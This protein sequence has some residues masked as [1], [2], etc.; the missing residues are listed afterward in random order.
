M[1]W[2]GEWRYKL[3]NYCNNGRY[4]TDYNWMLCGCKTI[5]ILRQSWE[6]DREK[7][8][9]VSESFQIRISPYI[10]FH[11]TY[12]VVADIS[13]IAELVFHQQRYFIGQVQADTT[14][15]RS[16][17][18]K[19]DEIFDRKGH[20]HTALEFDDSR[21][22]FLNTQLTGRDRKSFKLF[23]TDGVLFCWK[24]YAIDGSTSL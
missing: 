21:I 16:C 2:V 1:S 22:V 7:K 6:P 15:Q 20:G 4:N 12:Q 24:T 8:S 13:Q 23:D 3:D 14:W 19:V 18:C 5:S 9:W 11:S 10:P 17:F